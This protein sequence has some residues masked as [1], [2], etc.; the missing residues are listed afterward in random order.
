ME[1]EAFK[2]KDLIFGVMILPPRKKNENLTITSKTHSSVIFYTFPM[3]KH[4]HSSR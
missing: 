2:S 1:Y 3:A 4:I